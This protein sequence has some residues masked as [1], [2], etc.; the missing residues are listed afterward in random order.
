VESIGHCWDASVMRKEG[1]DDLENWRIDDRE[2]DGD[3]QRA[4]ANLLRQWGATFIAYAE[5]IEA[6]TFD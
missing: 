2:T 5:K 1:A 4:F 6:A 3:V